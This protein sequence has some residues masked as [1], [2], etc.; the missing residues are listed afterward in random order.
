VIGAIFLLAIVLSTKDMAAEITAAAGGA[1]PIA[2]A[3][4]DN[5]GE[6]FGYVYLA[7]V[8]TAVG[9]CLLAIQGATARLLFSMGRDR[10]VP[11]GATWGH[12]SP[13]FKT[14]TNAIVA[15]GVLAAIPLAITNSVAVLATGAT[16]VIYLS[17]F[18]CNVGVLLA[19]RR[20]WPHKPAWFKLGTWG[21]VINVLAVIYGAV[22]LVN[23][24]LWHI[25]DG[26]WTNA[27]R[28]ISNPTIN[29]LTFLGSGALTAL[30]AWPIFEVTVALIVIVGVVYY[31][32][33]ERDRVVTES[34]PKD[35]A[36]G[37]VAIS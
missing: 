9:V 36:T 20:G 8:L 29:T 10:R 3:I 33:V 4:H 2:D 37:E 18:L 5:L 19:R 23:F 12:V 7:V 16:G 21:L 31:L 35:V 17:Y 34:V 13:R 25:N 30:P 28:D 1:S 15:C 24:G 11:F 14:P 26:D 27:L 32:A 22:A 6:A